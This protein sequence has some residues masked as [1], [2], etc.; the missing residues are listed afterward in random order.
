V[1]KL[2]TK[3]ESKTYRCLGR[4]YFDLDTESGQ[5]ERYFKKSLEISKERGNERPLAVSYINLAFMCLH[6][7]KY[8]ESL[9]NVKCAIEII[10]EIGDRFGEQIALIHLAH[11]YYTL[12]NLTKAEEHLLKALHIIRE[13]GDRWRAHG[14]FSLGVF[15]AREREFENARTYL[16]ESISCIENNRQ[17]LLDEQQ[18]S[19]D[20]RTFPIYTELFILLLIQGYVVDALC[21]AE[22]RRARA[23]V[24]LM[25]K[26]YGIDVNPCSHEIRTAEIRNFSSQSQSTIIFIAVV[27]EAICFWIVEGRGKTR[28]TLSICESQEE[29]V[30][31]LF[32][33]S[34]K[35][36]LRFLLD[37]RGGKCEDHFFLAYYRVQSSTVEKDGEVARQRQAKEEDDKNEHDPEKQESPLHML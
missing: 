20:S 21:I 16:F 15:Y 29:S 23:L 11:V 12:G 28:F 22:R 25:S 1:K 3:A 18:L 32:E 35:Q 27:Q 37:G 36:S 17:Q 30:D 19:L 24:D 6:K 26:N 34:R 14:L 2:E 7:C 31:S 13:T 8:K 9:E 33:F 10:K 4:V 5:A